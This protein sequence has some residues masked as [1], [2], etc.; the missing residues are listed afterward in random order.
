MAGVAERRFSIWMFEPKEETIRS[1][2]R[3]SNEC[4]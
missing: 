2:A 4:Y 3:A 1:L